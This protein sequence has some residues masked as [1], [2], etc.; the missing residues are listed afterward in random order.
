M[1]QRA[2]R[3]RR[4]GH[5]AVPCAA[6]ARRAIPCAVTLLACALLFPLPPAAAQIQE[7][8]FRAADG[9]VYQVLVAAA[10]GGGAERLRITTVAGSTA[11][12]G[13]CV[14]TGSL[15]GD[16]VNAI[17]GV[18]PPGM[19]LHPFT[20]IRRSGVISGFDVT[21][22]S[23][24]GSFGGRVTIGPVAGTRTAVCGAAFDCTG[25]PDVQALFTLDVAAGGVPAACIAR[26]LNAGC[27]G[28]NLRDSLAFGLPASGSPPE[29]TNPSQVTVESTLCGAEPADGFTLQ[30]GEAIV[31]VYSGAV[32]QT[33]GFAVAAGGLGITADASNPAGCGSDQVVSATAGDASQPAPPPSNTPTSTPTNTPT[34]TTTATSTPTNTRTF[35]P[36]FTITHTPGGP[37]TPTGT[38]TATA[39]HT[40]AGA[41]QVSLPSNATIAAVGNTA[42][43]PVSIA[44]TTGISGVDIRFTYAAAIATATLVQGTPLTASCSV[45]ANLATP[46]LVIVSAACP[47]GLP[48]GQSGALFDVTFLGVANGT[49]PLGF[50]PATG[51]L[52]NEG[53]PTCQ[54]IDGQLSVGPVLP[55]STASA[56]A[57]ATDTQTRTPTATPSAAVPPATA[58]VTATATATG[59]ITATATDT[60]SATATPSPTG[61]VAPFCGDGTIDAGEI[62]DDAN[63]I[64]NDGC[65]PNCTVSTACSMLYQGAE[66]FVGGC[67]MPTYPHI[68]AAVDAASDGDTVTVCPGTYTQSVLVTKEVQIRAFT[69]GTVSVQTAGTAFDIRRSGVTIDGLGITAAGGA[70]ITADAICPRGQAICAAPGRGSNLTIRDNAISNSA[71]G[72]GWQR[73]V[74]CVRIENN[75]MADN[76]AH[77]DLRQQEG[78]PAVLV[79]I[80]AN[81]ITNG[82]A[83]GAALSL[84]GL[85]ATVAAN[86]IVG[87]ATAGILLETMGAGSQVIENAIAGSGGDGITVRAGAAATRIHD[88]NITDN[89]VGLGNESGGLVDATLNWWDSQTGPSGIFS[90]AGDAIVNRGAGATTE[91]LEFLCKPFPQGFPSILGACSTET[92]ELRQL[93]PGRHPDL[94][95][96]G[97]HVAFASNGNAD[98]DTRTAHANADGSQEIFLL[99]RRPKR[100]LGGVCLGG[101]SP[102]DFANVQACQ[103]CSGNADCAGDPGADPIVLNGECVLVTQISDGAA[104]TTS[105][106][107]RMS[108]GTKQVVFD[109]DA[110]LG[111]TNADGSREVAIWSRRDFEQAQPPL[112][113]SSAGVPPDTYAAPVPAISGR[114]VAMES[115]GNPTGTNA[116]GNTEIFLR[117]PR[118]GEW[119]QI[120]HTVAPAESR[121]PT[122][123]DGRRVLFD[124]TADL[125]GQ[126]ADGN[127]ELFLAQVAGGGQLA[128]RQITNTLSPGDSRAGSMDGTGALV[129]FSSTADLVGQNADGSRE[130]FTWARRTGAFAQITHAPAGESTNPAINVGQRFIVFEST[131]DLTG[132]GATNRRIFLYDRER[133]ELVLLSRSRFGTNQ[134]PRINRRRFVIWESTANLT[135]NNPGG[136]WVL[137][138]FDIKK[139]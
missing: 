11:G 34:G 82:G 52:L 109:T 64:A 18:L 129:V 120:T 89:A 51:C 123:S 94:D 76:A 90:G 33:S 85:S 77:I 17:G 49:T 61:T 95:T 84:S 130:I 44:D 93:A 83:S 59:T 22:L 127:R 135:G 70:A 4:G 39:T 110:D 128:L 98:V 71:V 113:P 138:L 72:I 50:V 16:P 40:A 87:A 116:D 136:D 7:T 46:G 53:T 29:C 56:T 19:T 30:D 54:A 25:Q 117:Y 23:F 97:R 20:D 69:A 131:A 28:V 6:P 139:D 124:S 58:T 119:I 74:D 8:A 121:R 62:C 132:S 105:G 12:A 35:T 37:S 101:L 21:A 55:T 88:N 107:P 103:P 68:Q 13:S 10:L 3:R 38:A 118:S 78:V 134:A 111:G 115:N 15:P 14:S 91:F 31:F 104:G 2:Q 5:D 36:V 67:G 86:A 114:V 99:N 32:L 137:Y 66:R 92:A 112:A 48:S 100:A 1:S 126:N 81:D 42:S 26:T 80:V 45:A 65:E 106:A 96:F 122:T 125:T 75:T 41:V 102:C 47:S 60:P 133:A 63:A 9:T 27:D 73:R 43:V 57:T 108:G 79:D 24:D